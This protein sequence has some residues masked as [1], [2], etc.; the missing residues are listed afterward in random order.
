MTLTLM[1]FMDNSKWM[2]IVPKVRITLEI[3]LIITLN[4]SKANIFLGFPIFFVHICQPLFSIFNFPHP[5]IIQCLTPIPLSSTSSAFNHCP[6]FST[7]RTHITKIYV[8]G[9]KITN[10]NNERIGLNQNSKHKTKEPRQ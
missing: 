9:T 7:S 3:T 4:K 2:N 8:K 10:T 1:D 5:H 6:T